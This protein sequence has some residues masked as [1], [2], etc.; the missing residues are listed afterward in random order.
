MPHKKA[1]SLFSK[2][3]SVKI[4]WSI[5]RQNEAALSHPQSKGLKQQNEVTDLLTQ[6][7]TKGSRPSSHDADP[8][9]SE[10]NSAKITRSR[11]RPTE[12]VLSHPPYKGSQG[13]VP[14]KE[15]TE[16]PTRPPVKE[17]REPNPEASP[18]VPKKNPLEIVGSAK[19]QKEAALSRPPYKGSKV[20]KQMLNAFKRTKNVER[21]QK[22]ETSPLSVS[23]DEKATMSQIGAPQAT[24]DEVVGQS[25]QSAV[26][27][28]KHGLLDS[29]LT[30]PNPQKPLEIV[31][32]K[33][34]DKYGYI[35]QARAESIFY[36]IRVYSFTQEDASER[37]QAKRNCREWKARRRFSFSWKKDDLVFLVLRNQGDS[38]AAP[39]LDPPEPQ[40]NSIP[41]FLN[42]IR[43]RERHCKDE[44]GRGYTI[45]QTL[46]VNFHPSTLF[47]PNIRKKTTAQKERNR[48]VQQK[49]RKVKRASRRAV[50]PAPDIEQNQPAISPSPENFIAQHPYDD[51]TA[52]N[53]HTLYGKRQK[54]RILATD[55][56]SFWSPHGGWVEEL[57]H[58]PGGTS[59]YGTVYSVHGGW[60]PGY[61]PTTQVEELQKDDSKE[62]TSNLDSKDGGSNYRPPGRAM[63]EEKTWQTKAAPNGSMREPPKQYGSAKLNNSTLSGLVKIILE[64]LFS[65]DNLCQD[66]PLRKQ[67]DLSG[68]V[69]LSYFA[70]V[71]RVSRLTSDMNTILI[72]CSRSDVLELKA[73][74][75]DGVEAMFVRRKE[76]WEEWVLLKENVS[77]EVKE[78]EHGNCEKCGA[79]VASGE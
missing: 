17:S 19:R 37:R 35:Y 75:S 22:E 64:Y 33:K 52:E 56:N 2:N 24:K 69:P 73:D 28:D 60:L 18:F 42:L 77:T 32:V 72:S 8:F 31:R 40:R 5:K 63:P 30:P 50:K 12:A 53:D 26:I 4:T 58:V 67:M 16:L 66:E 45:P 48:K 76:G 27:E 78:I 39:Y 51:Q 29:V 68:F 59:Q 62:Q 36:E 41:W 44:S 57:V 38:M 47:V 79:L 13:A 46:D 43:S 65:P 6:P 25:V 55:I 9:V 23:F 49:K 61:A 3:K 14:Q 20:P 10:K 70:I 15:V 34:S 71:R 1:R 74:K 11:K 54:P 7:P 21:S